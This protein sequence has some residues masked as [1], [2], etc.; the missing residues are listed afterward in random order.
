MIN[1]PRR[2]WL[3]AMARGLG[4]SIDEAHDLASETLMKLLSQTIVGNPQPLAKVILRN[5]WFDLC[6]SYGRRMS[7]ELTPELE[8]CVRDRQPSNLHAMIEQE[9]CEIIR[10]AIA[11]LPRK[12][13]DTIDL[14]CEELDY[15]T[16]GQRLGVSVGTISSRVNRAR[17]RLSKALEGR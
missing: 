12:H 6:K 3:Y 7:A 2:D 14:L 11:D 9:R 10:A 16:I 17:K 8:C 13:R 4:A 15:A 1:L 5:L